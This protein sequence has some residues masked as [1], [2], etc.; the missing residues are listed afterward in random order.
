[1]HGARIRPPETSPAQ[2]FPRVSITRQLSAIRHAALG[3][4]RVLP[5]A[6]SEGVAEEMFAKG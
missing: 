1:M 2:A 6:M 5:V 4:D 3:S